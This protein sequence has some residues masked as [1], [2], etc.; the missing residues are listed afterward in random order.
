MVKNMSV[1]AKKK[2]DGKPPLFNGPYYEWKSVREVERGDSIVVAQLET[3]VLGVRQQEGSWWISYSHPR[4]GTKV[5][6]IYTA[7]DFLYMRLQQE[8]E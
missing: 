7:N 3:L 6:E 1:K 8:G 5:E 2:R 4:T